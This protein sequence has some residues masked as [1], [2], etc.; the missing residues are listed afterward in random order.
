[1]ASMDKVLVDTCVLLDDPE[2]LVRIRQRGGLPFLTITVL[3]EL[4]YQKDAIKRNKQFQ[5]EVE[6]R[7][8]HEN[9]RNA[10]LIFRQFS[11]AS[12]KLKSLPTGQAL[13]GQDVL[14]QFTFRDEPV[15]LIGRETFRS[16]SNNDAKIIELAKDY[17]MVL[18]T[19]DNGMKV[20]A[21]ALGVDVAF[22]SGPSE[23]SGS[24]RSSQ[25]GAQDTVSN[26]RQQS[27]PVQAARAP[28]ELRPF[29]LCTTVIA[30]ADAPITVRTI[31]EA[32]EPAKLSSGHEFRLGKLISSGGEGSIY[33]TDLAGHV[34]KIYHRNRLTKLK[35]KKIELMVSRKIKR[36]GICWPTE[37]VSN[38]D[39]EFVGYVMPR[40]AG[41]TMQSAMFVKPKLE[42]TFPN[43]KR[44]DLVNVAGNFINQIN[45]LHSLN[46][47]VGDINPLN[48]LV[49]E[50]STKVWIV[51]TDSFQIEN[52]PCTVGTVNFTP[53]EIQGKN[54]SEFLRTKEH[55]LF[56]VA[57]MIF[58]ILFPGKPPYSQQGGGSPAENIKSKNFPYRY[59]K[60][61]LQDAPDVDGRNAPQGSWQYIWSSLPPAI[62]S[63]FFS[64]FREDKRTS[65]DTWTDLLV[66]YRDRID[67]RNWTNDLF[68][69]G[70]KIRE[71]V[72][73][74]CPR[75]S[76]TFSAERSWV[77]KL[78]LEGKQVW[79]PDCASRARVERL[80]AQSQR[81]TARLTGDATSYDKAA[82][83]SSSWRARLS[84]KIVSKT[85]TSNPAL[86]PAQS[87]KPNALPKTPSG[88]GRIF[89]AIRGVAALALVVFSI[90]K[91]G[92]FGTIFGAVFAI[93]WLYYKS[94]G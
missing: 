18:I 75:C 63:A 92:V 68:P 52:F 39:G 56:A 6:E 59:S 7:R 29:A 71:P 77:E 10:R 53:P 51:D 19:R 70:Y 55:E 13:L 44:R 73:S 24:Q 9:A 89:S 78:T 3:D 45:F 76:V 36:P 41:T 58:M 62:K 32:G 49:T 14:T 74:K 35:Q 79:C 34:C 17:K 91:L 60:D 43:W 25:S 40:A 83:A 28:D 37:I 47:I 65:I 1:M 81:A 38:C 33:E 48:L 2:V 88:S 87:Y 61:R 42:K 5:S 26:G 20:R 94:R 82:P 80:A 46:I 84:S 8:A 4:D 64:T 12:V 69:S 30:E 23:P 93:F 16:D 11:G 21:E 54:Y 27:S 31:P 22:W 85:S 57:T 15:F 66:D 90:Y 72:Q 86:A 67:N 50:D